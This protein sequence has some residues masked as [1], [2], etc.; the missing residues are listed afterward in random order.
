MNQVNHCLFFTLSI[1]HTGQ[2]CLF[3]RNR[4]DY[5]LSD[6][7]GKT[8][9]DMAIKSEHADIVTLLRLAHMDEEMRTGETSQ[10]DDTFQEIVRDIAQRAHLGQ[11]SSSTTQM[12]FGSLDT[13]TTAGQD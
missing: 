10:T 4:A 2:I 3:L 5:Q 11:E 8:P 9:L 7:E 6:S 13:T 12:D 1:G